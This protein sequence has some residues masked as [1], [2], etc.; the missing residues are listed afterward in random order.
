MKSALVST[1]LALLVALPAHAATYSYSFLNEDG[2]IAGTVAGTIVLPD[3]DGTFG[4]TSVFV[5]TAP[6]GLGYD[7]TGFN[8]AT[9]TFNNTFTVAAGAVVASDFFG[10]FN[11]GTALSIGSTFGGG[12]TFLDAF[13]A[14]DFGASGL[15]DSDSS[16][17]TY[18]AVPLPAGM[19]L[20]L[21]G[22][23]AI[24]LVARKRHAA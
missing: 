11:P 17:L 23:G 6:A 16:T 7:P 8:F 12:S 18:A 2:A 20:L 22:L 1:V 24:G 15:L 3:G 9:D 10:R 4:A 13:N 5:T 14:V 19:P 21:A